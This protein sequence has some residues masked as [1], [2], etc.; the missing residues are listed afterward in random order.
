MSEENMDKSVSSTR[1]RSSAPSADVRA[2][3]EYSALRARRAAHL[4]KEKVAAKRR[5]VT[6][7]AGIVVAIVFATLAA[8]GLIGW[9]WMLIPAG[10]LLATL[11]ASAVAGERTKKQIDADN[12]RIA[13]LRRSMSRSSLGPSRAVSVPKISS[14]TENSL[15]ADEVVDEERT[16]SSSSIPQAVLSSVEARAALEV[17]DQ[18][19]EQHQVSTRRVSGG[20]WDFVPLPAPSYARKEKIARRVVHPDTDI[21][22]VQP[23]ASIVVPGRPTRATTPAAEEIVETSTASNPTF[24]FDLD[25][26][27]DQ[28]RAQ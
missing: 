28:R 11:A 10:F 1:P 7:G 17:S 12:A 25:A 19:D 13:E 26:V 16:P 3:Q 23:L 2:A 9:L 21:V 6:A 14:L 18:N 5:L 4:S 15:S 24:K 22:S 27:L 20:E 8:T